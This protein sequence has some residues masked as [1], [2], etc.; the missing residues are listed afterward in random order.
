[1]KPKPTIQLQQTTHEGIAVIQLHFKYDFKLKE[2]VKRLPGA[3]WS[4]AMQC[5]FIPEQEFEQAI[6]LK[7]LEPMAI[8]DADAIL[9]NKKNNALPIVNAK[10]N[11][12]QGADLK[13]LLRNTIKVSCDEKEKTFYLSLPYALK[14]QFK[15]LEGAWWHGKK[16]Q[17]S[18]LDTPE[19]RAQLNGM[20]SKASLKVEYSVVLWEKGKNKKVSKPGIDKGKYLGSLSEEHHTAI[21]TFKKWMIQKR[22]AEN[23]VK[24]YMACITIFFRFYSDKQIADIGIKDI[25]KF[26]FDF[27]IKNNYSPKTQNQYISAIKT[28]YIKMKGIKYEL[29]N[30]ERPIEG[31]KLPKVLSIETVQQMLAGIANIK[32]KTALTTIYAL[33]L[34]RSELLNLKLNHINFDR[35]VVAVIN[36]KGKK[37]RDLPL[38]V[39]L[40][41]LILSYLSKFNPKIWLIEGQEPATPYSAT[42]LENIFK[43]NLDRVLKDNIFTLHC[44]RHSYATHL[45]DM[46][47]DLRIIQELLGHKSS[48]TTEIYTHVSMKNLKNVKNPLDEITGIV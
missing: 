43:K 23:T 37:D 13:K 3:Q 10:Q 28:F 22:Y 15:K 18:A 32:H 45:L 12:F 42:S 41:Q 8:V 48:R 29:T 24:I 25:E 21:E 7:A 47:V 34:R 4:V 27:I 2:Q 35:D 5:W 17:W 31:F 6:V 30:I 44:L 1:M 26:N 14:E 33:G 40:K 36:S 9:G 11:S 46:G 19:N 20:L 38:P 16:K 39:S